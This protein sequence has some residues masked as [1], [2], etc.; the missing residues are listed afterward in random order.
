MHTITLPNNKTYTF[1]YD[2][3][4]GLLNEIIYPDGG[5]VKYTWEMSPVY[6]Q[7]AVYSGLEQSGYLLQNGCVYLYKT[8]VVQTRQV[9]FD[10]STVALTQT[11]TYNASWNTNENLTNQWLTKSTTVQTTDAVTGLTSQT[12]YTYS[13]VTIPPPSGFGGGGEIASQVAVEQ[14]VQVYNWG[15]T[16]TPIRQDVKQWSDQFNLQSDQ[17][18]IDNTSTSE[19]TYTYGFG[20][21]VTQKRNMILARA[22]PAT[23]SEPPSTHTRHSRKIRCFL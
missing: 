9:S 14:E 20:G 13:P 22:R 16:T 15:N 10:G 21:A 3:T 4:Y 11:F 2:S 5:W 23:C 19:V 8:P 18:T 17:T 12:I 7:S 1:S 6:T